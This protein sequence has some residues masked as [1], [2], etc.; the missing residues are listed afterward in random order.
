VV[1]K[2]TEHEVIIKEEF[3]DFRGNKQYKEVVKKIPS[4]LL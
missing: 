1:D 3:K 4:P 2:I